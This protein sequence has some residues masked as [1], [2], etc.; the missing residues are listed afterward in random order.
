VLRYASRNPS[1]SNGSLQHVAATTE[2]VRV[3]PTPRAQ[4]IP[5]DRSKDLWWTI[6]VAIGGLGIIVLGA[7]LVR[8]GR[9][10]PKKNPAWSSASMRTRNHTRARS[11]TNLSAAPVTLAHSGVPTDALLTRA[12]PTTRAWVA[13][14]SAVT[15]PNLAT[16]SKT[17]AATTR[18]KLPPASG[19]PDAA[20][21]TLLN[22]IE[23][24]LNVEHAVRRV[25]AIAL[26]HI[27]RDIGSDAILKAIEAAER[28]LMLAPLAPVDNALGH[29]LDNELLGAKPA[30]KK[31][32]A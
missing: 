7:I 5:I 29:A 19:T 21:D 13:P 16:T 23:A 26:N 9:P 31:A 12:A 11:I 3:T 30:P 32:A 18:A 6:A 28:D 15:Q 20:L 14:A 25:H 8:Q 17:S 2:S 24:D 4:S 22:E 10:A 1:E 27:E